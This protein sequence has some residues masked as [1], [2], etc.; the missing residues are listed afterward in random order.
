RAR[1]ATS[2]SQ[3]AGAI[4]VLVSHFQPAFFVRNR[5]QR[6]ELQSG[7]VICS[8]DAVVLLTVVKQSVW[9]AISG[10]AVAQNRECPPIVIQLA[11][12]A[13]RFGARLLRRSLQSLKRERYRTLTVLSQISKPRFRL[14]D[15]R[16]VA[17]RNPPQREMRP[18]H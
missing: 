12:N 16:H 18:R 1:L 5:H 10:F 15:R 11:A 4:D 13:T 8:P 14:F 2:G 9:T 17:C 3:I 7:P 6:S